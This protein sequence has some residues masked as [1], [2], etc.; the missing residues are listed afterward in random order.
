VGA[1][2]LTIGYGGRDLGEVFELL[3]R[4]EVDYLVDVRSFPVSRRRPEFSRASLE[5]ALAS[6]QIRYVFMGDTLGGRPRDPACYDDDGHVDY[7]RCQRQP[8]FREGL[9]RLRAAARGG[10][11]LALLCSE[12]QPEECHRTKLVGEALTEHGV[13]VRHI[14]KDGVLRSHGEIMARL[15]EPQ[16]TLLGASGV[17]TRSRNAYR[18]A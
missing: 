15:I 14:D 11:A 17:A 18:S 7:G 16:L 6:S 9:R 13:D 2:V 3:R 12:V 4:S 10:H 1:S 5:S 8:A